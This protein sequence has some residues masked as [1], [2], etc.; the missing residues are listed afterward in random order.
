MGVSISIP[1]GH[2]LYAT[3]LDLL[4]KHNSAGES[5]E[6]LKPVYASNKNTPEYMAL[7]AVLA[8]CGGNVKEYVRLIAHYLRDNDCG[9]WLIE[10]LAGV[11]KMTVGDLH[12]YHR[13]LGKPQ[14]TTGNKLFESKWDSD[15]KRMVFYVTGPMR[16]ALIRSFP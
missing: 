1:E 16:E 9:A 14:K 11:G 13:L 7:Q 3:V 2:K 12:S 8:R 6:S 4:I 15:F 5:D 10:D